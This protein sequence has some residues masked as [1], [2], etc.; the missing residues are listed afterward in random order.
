MDSIIEKL[1]IYGP[2]KLFLYLYFEL[3]NKLFWQMLM[4]SY[5]QRQEDLV[6]DRLL[7][8]KTRG[9]YVDIGAYDPERFSNTKRFYDKGWRG[10]NVEPHLDNYKK[11]LKSRSEDINLNLGIGTSK[12][13]ATFYI[14][15]PSILST[16]SSSEAESYQKQGY[17]LVKKEQIKLTPLSEIL[18]KYVKQAKIDFISIDTEGYDMEVLKSNDWDIHKPTIVCIESIRHHKDGKDAIRHNEHEEYLM[19]LGY[20]KVIDN[21]LNIIYKI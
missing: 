6:I 9:F 3:R 19:K 10:I 15:S 5:G 12:K 20:Q 7:K 2:I 16:F 11:F 1:R 8:Y 18:R 21:N 17:K 4:K 13:N 14:F